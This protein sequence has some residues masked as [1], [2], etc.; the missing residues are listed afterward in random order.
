[1]LY[2]HKNSAWSQIN[3]YPG[4]H[5]EW[6]D[7]MAGFVPFFDR[8]R[9]RRDHRRPRWLWN[10]RLGLRILTEGRKATWDLIGI[11]V[12]RRRLALS[13]KEPPGAEG[14][15]WIETTL[16]GIFRPA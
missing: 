7:H 13:F 1:M 9:K 6:F 4:L 11:E 5:F 12:G 8:L 16:R 15:A 2:V 10:A 3:R 14:Y